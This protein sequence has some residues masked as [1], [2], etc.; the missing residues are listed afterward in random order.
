M[1]QSLSKGESVLKPENKIEIF[2]EESSFVSED[3]Q[4][5]FN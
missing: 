5:S 2:E 1:I 3:Y 4:N